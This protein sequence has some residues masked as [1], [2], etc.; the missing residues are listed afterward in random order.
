MIQKKY[1]SKRFRATRI[2][3][4]RPNADARLRNVFAAIGVP[5]QR[6]FRPDVFQLEALA[7]IEHADCLVTAPTGAGKTWIAE[8][9]IAR[10]YEKGLKSWYASPLKALTNSK[11]DEFG[12]IF[13]AEHVGI[14]TGDRKENADAPIIVGTTEILRNQL[15]DAM[16]LGGD[17]ATDLVI[18]DEAHFL[19]DRD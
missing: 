19:G 8:R 9:A 13:G 17:V 6:P 14:L 18:L 7:A 1:R 11:Y 16:H 2:P 15:Y 3:P 10:C 5:E 12:G 4:I